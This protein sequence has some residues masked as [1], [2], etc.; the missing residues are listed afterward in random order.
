MS[1][2]DQRKQITTMSIGSIAGG[3]LAGVSGLWWWDPGFLIPIGVVIG[4]SVG[5]AVAAR[6]ARDGT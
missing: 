3:V 5:G 2:V 6:K 4:L 1:Q